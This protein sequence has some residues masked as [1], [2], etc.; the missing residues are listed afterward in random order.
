MLAAV[1]AFQQGFGRIY[2][3][4]APNVVRML[5]AALTTPVMLYAL[6][7]GCFWIASRWDAKR[8]EEIG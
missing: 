1:T 6:P 7:L 4:E 2:G 8:R 5:H 3:I